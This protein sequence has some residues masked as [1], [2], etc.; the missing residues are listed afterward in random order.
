VIGV[1]TQGF[2]L[3]KRALYLLSR[4]SSPFCSHYFGD[5][6]SETICPGFS[7][8]DLSLPSR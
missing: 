1:W 5:G 8:L 6:V 3:A 7:P 2:P 4:A